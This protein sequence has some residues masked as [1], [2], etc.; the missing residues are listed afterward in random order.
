MAGYS[1]CETV[2]AGGNARWHIRALTRKGRMLGGGADTLALC[3]A[4]AAWDLAV[5]LT[6]HHLS[7]SCPACVEAFKKCTTDTLSAGIDSL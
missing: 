2:T 4:K 7:H 5:A 3:G 6:E 1:F